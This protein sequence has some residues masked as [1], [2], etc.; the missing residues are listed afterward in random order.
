MTV[1]VLFVFRSG[2]WYPIGREFSCDGDGLFCFFQ[3]AN[4]LRFAHDYTF[5]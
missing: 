1:N 5:V 3:F 2:S 4:R